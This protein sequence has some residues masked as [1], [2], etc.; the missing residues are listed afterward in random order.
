MSAAPSTKTKTK[1]PTN[2][3]KKPVTQGV[4]NRR[5]DKETTERNA[6]GWHCHQGELGFQ[7]SNALIVPSL[8]R[9]DMYIYLQ[10]YM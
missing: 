8:Q 10:M 3:T 1:K 2:Q 7:I 9:Q 6:E 4:K 5:K